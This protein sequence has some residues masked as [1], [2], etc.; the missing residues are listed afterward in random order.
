MA[1]FLIIGLPKGA[2]RYT[3]TMSCFK[4][5]EQHQYISI[6]IFPHFIQRYIFR[7]RLSLLFYLFCLPFVD[8]VFYLAMNT[9]FLFLLRLAQLL[10][11]RVFVDFFS[12]RYMIATSDS[13]IN[14]K[15]LPSSLSSKYLRS[16]RVRL[17]TA[18]DLITLTLYEYD[19]FYK[20]AGIKTPV[21]QKSH[22]LPIVI[23][24]SD[25]QLIPPSR[26][27]S[28][29]SDPFNI[30]WWGYAS[31]LHGLDYLIDEFAV[32]LTHKPNAYFHLFDPSKSRTDF[33]KSAFLSSLPH[34]VKEHICINNDLTMKNGL[35]DWLI[36][37][38]HAS[39]GPLGF[40][41]QG[42]SSIAN[43]LIEC[44]SLKLPVL[45]QRS[46]PLRDLSRDHLAFFVDEKNPGNALDQLSTIYSL[47]INNSHQLDYFT[48][49]SYQYYLENHSPEEF[50]RRLTSIL[51]SNAL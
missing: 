47:Y 22:V 2:N 13:K 36:H 35:R 16:D 5:S 6:S 48:N 20:W 27:F 28:N 33:F 43:K 41:D 30:C 42:M 29:P 50:N 40:T 8:S 10:D 4:S 12:S 26:K 7:T 24:R 51:S 34:H 17:S 45:T 44:W 19:Q 46:I 32:F 15:V 49:L 3:D 38:C 21:Q 39:V 11:K 14:A 37:N 31:K 25:T 1:K 9:D 18:S 23:Q